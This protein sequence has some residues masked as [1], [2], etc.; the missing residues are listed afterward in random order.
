MTFKISPSDAIDPSMLKRVLV[1]KLRHH[2]DVLLTTP[3]LHALKLA[4]PQAE[5]DVLVYA[6]TAPL[7]QGNP[8]LTQTH[9][10]DKRWKKQGLLQQ[11]RSEWALYQQLRARQYD[12]IVHLTEHQ[13]GAWLVRALKP[14][15]AVAPYI[16]ASHRFYGRFQE[17]F[18]NNS[19]THRYHTESTIVALNKR[20]TVEQNLDALRRLGLV[21]TE[22]RRLVLCP[23]LAAQQVVT[24][25]LSEQG[26]SP[27]QFIVLHPGARWLFKCW[28]VER[29]AEL[30]VHLLRA[31]K[32]ILLTAAPD[33]RELALRD[34][35]VQRV[36][37]KTRLHDFCGQLSLQELAALIGQAQLFIGVDSAPM[38]IAAA[39]QTPVV[40]L[41]GPSGEQAWAPWQVVHR[42]ITSES[43][44]CRP[45]GQDGC[46]G[47]KIS[48]CLTHLPVARVLRAVEELI[49]ERVTVSPSQETLQQ[50][51]WMVRQ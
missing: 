26:V 9:V 23:D 25:K 47:G 27:R 19:F 46:G 10:I 22:D 41:F 42:V 29:N 15:T 5:V 39:M 48:E 35:I 1:I 3:V 49:A 13:R 4:A 37:D 6:E 51:L 2:G 36:P 20:H 24:Q 45:C 21:V 16:R 12:L 14:R 50:P 7:L 18:W 32:T 33:P 43:H 28:S 30:I 11:A 38:H 34:A 31:G 17:R 40:T 8:D 44:A